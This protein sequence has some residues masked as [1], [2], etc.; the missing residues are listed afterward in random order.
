MLTFILDNYRKYY[1][2]KNKDEKLNNEFKNYQKLL[3]NA[4]IIILIVGFSSYLIQKK[5]EYKSKFNLKK[6]IFGVQKCNSL[7]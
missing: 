2:K 1:Y 4:A 3:I 6:F 7:K 5:Y